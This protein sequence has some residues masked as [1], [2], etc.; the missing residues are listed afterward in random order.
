MIIWNGEVVNNLRD[1]CDIVRR[2]LGNDLADFMEEAVNGVNEEY[3]Q[4]ELQFQNEERAHELH[5]EE[6][7][8]VVRD[9][10]DALDEALFDVEHEMFDSFKVPKKRLNRKAFEKIM[11]D[12]DNVL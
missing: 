9:A 10:R 2:E 12:L 5:C 11:E 4:L 1:V 7:M 8:N 6:W 3:G